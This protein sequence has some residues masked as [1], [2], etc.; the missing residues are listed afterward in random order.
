MPGFIAKLVVKEGCEAE[1]ERLQDELARLTEEH[2][3]GTEVYDVIRHQ[4]SPRTYVCYAR[5]KDQAAFD[6][7]QAS[8][9]HER[10]VPPIL[11]CLAEDM[12]LSFYDGVSVL[13]RSSATFL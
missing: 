9:F 12:E 5:F 8:S 2:E 13:S 4:E 1:F 11:D 10:L 7:H 6:E 3:P